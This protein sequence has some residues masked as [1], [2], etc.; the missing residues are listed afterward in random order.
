EVCHPAASTR[1]RRKR[2]HRAEASRPGPGQRNPCPYPRGMFADGYRDSCG[3]CSWEFRLPYG[4]EIVMVQQRLKEIAASAANRVG[5]PLFLQ[6]AGQLRQH[7]LALALLGGGR[8]RTQNRLERRTHK[9]GVG[10]SAQML[11]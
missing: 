7:L 5:T 8:R 10:K 4:D 6:Q 9:R 11:M 1:D 3:V 2:S